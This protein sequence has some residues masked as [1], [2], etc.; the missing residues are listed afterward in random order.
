MKKNFTTKDRYQLLTDKVIELMQQHGT[1]WTKPWASS[2]SSSHHNKF[3]KTMY[4]GT[5]T[6]WT[7]LSCYI[8]GFTC[9]EWATFKQWKKQGYNVKK[10]SKGTDI[11]YFDFIE[12]KNP[13]NKEEKDIIPMLK[14]FVVFNG[15]QIDNYTPN[16]I[17]DNKIVFDNKRIEDL[18]VTSKAQIKHGGDKAFYNTNHDFIQMP[19]KQD[20]TGT[21]TST[22]EQSYYN[23]LLH[24]L[25]H[26]TGH[27][28]RLNREFGKRFGSNAYAFEELVAETSSSFLCCLLGLNH[29]PSKDNATYLNNWLEVLKKDKKAMVKA[30][31]MAQKASDYILQYDAELKKAA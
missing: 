23:T 13:N 14:G 28:S 4:K 15:E 5:N 27:S 9:N 8:N 16:K 29:T 11:F 2:V 12:V 3:T 21:D 26:W 30:F 10:G 7:G 6:F 18:I 31:G 1:N 17:E 22:N 24:E 20:F 19:N 25:S